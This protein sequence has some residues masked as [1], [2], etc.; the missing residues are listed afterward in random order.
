MHQHEKSDIQDGGINGSVGKHRV[1]YISGSD[2]NVVKNSQFDLKNRIV[3]KKRVIHHQK[4]A[5]E[6]VDGKINIEKHQPEIIHVAAKL[7]ENSGK[8]HRKTGNVSN[9]PMGTRNIRIVEVSRRRLGFNHRF[10]EREIEKDTH[11][12]LMNKGDLHKVKMVSKNPIDE[13]EDMLRN[14]DDVYI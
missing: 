9:R 13:I 10:K 3:K 11:V 12:R 1:I 4:K 5:T 8:S 6:I 7:V 2:N 14:I